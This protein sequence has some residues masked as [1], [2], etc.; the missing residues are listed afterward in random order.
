M[1]FIKGPVQ[2]G[3]NFNAEATLL[4]RCFETLMRFD[5]LKPQ[6]NY[7]HFAESKSICNLLKNGSKGTAFVFNSPL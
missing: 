1:Y 6:Q 3:C 4:F 5:P 2:K 7:R